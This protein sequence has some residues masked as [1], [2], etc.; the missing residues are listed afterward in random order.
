MDMWQKGGCVVYDDRA[1]RPR[2]LVDRSVEA[3]SGEERV[4][5]AGADLIHPRLQPVEVLV[6]AAGDDV[7]DLGVGEL[8]AELA[9]QLL[10]GVAEHARRR[11]GNRVHRLARGHQ[12]TLDGAREL[13]IEQQ[14]LDDAARDACGRGASGTSRTRW[15]S[16]AP[17][18]TGCRRTVVPTSA[19]VGSSR[20]YFTSR[21]REVLSARSSWRPSRQ[22]CQPSLCV[23][24]ASV[25]PANDVARH[26]HGRRRDRCGS[27]RLSASNCRRVDHQVELVQ[28]LPHLRGDDLADR[29]RVLA[30]RA[31]AG[32]NRVRVLRI[33][34]EELDDAL[35]RGGAVPRR[36]LLCVAGRVDQRLPLLRRAAPAGRASG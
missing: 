12:A 22:K 23:I 19:A 24:V 13:A 29:P 8:G 1:A 32:E 6:Q 25:T 2:P 34:G 15:P 5:D 36:E 27:L 26:L 30:R 10:D 17:P 7:L 14:E 4:V 28:L 9:E 16:G 31:Q 21:M 3:G 20:K 18:P 35:L 33:E 11:A